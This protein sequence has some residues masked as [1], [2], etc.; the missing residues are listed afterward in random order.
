MIFFSDFLSTM[1]SMW[2]LIEYLYNRFIMKICKQTQRAKMKGVIAW[3]SSWEKAKQS[4]WVCD[5][6]LSLIEK[7]D[8]QTIALYH[9]LPDELDLRWVID[10][11]LK[12][13]KNLLLPRIR[14]GVM[15]F[16]Q[17]SSL[18]DLSI[19][20]FGIQEPS[21]SLDSWDKDIDLIIVPGRAFDRKWGRLGRGWG[22]YDKY[23]YFQK[24]QK[25]QKD[26]K[27]NLPLVIW[28]CFREQVVDDVPMEEWDVRMDKVL[29]VEK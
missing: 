17:M 7:H 11:C 2:N 24:F 27:K 21:Q 15:E 19:G 1:N 20:N 10:G 29:F 28:A 26:Q 23:L 22:F 6:L 3:L 25:I 12:Q 16:C 18:E 5:V 14:E 9:A 13:K 8:F 4:Q